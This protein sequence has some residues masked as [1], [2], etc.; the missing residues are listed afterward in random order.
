MP[1]QLASVPS[2]ISSVY[3]Y[4]QGNYWLSLEVLGYDPNPGGQLGARTVAQY[5]KQI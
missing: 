1:F 5:L 3:Y 4:I 2:S